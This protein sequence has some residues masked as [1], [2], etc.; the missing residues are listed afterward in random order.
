MDDAREAEIRRQR[1][2]LL[3]LQTQ[4]ELG[5]ELGTIL[6]RVRATTGHSQRTCHPQHEHEVVPDSGF[7]TMPG[8][9]RPLIASLQQE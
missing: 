2:E 7:Y 1:S 4:A 5:T 3:R 9:A 6:G 8:L